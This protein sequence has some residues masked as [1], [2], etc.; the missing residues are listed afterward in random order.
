MEPSRT[1][2]RGKVFCRLSINSILLSCGNAGAC[3]A[4]LDLCMLGIFFKVTFHKQT[5]NN[6]QMSADH[7]LKTTVLKPS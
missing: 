1:S 2:E 3:I 5:R 7:S 6:P 4:N